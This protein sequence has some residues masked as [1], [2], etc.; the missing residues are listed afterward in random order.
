MRTILSLT[1]K[2]FRLFWKDKVAIALCFFVPMFLITV[3]GMIFTKGSGGPYGIRLLVVDEAQSDASAKLLQYLHDEDTF[4]VITDRQME[5]G[6]RVPIDRAYGQSLLEENAGSYRYLL[7]F[8]EDLLAEDFGLNLE[9][10]YNPQNGI[11]NGI[12]QG[13]LQKTLFSR[14]MPLLLESTQY[15]ITDDIR[16][17]F[18]TGMAGLIAEHFGGD[19]DQI[20]NEMRSNGFWGTGGGEEGDSDADADSDSDSDPDEDLFGGMF[21]FKKT[22][23]FG[24]GKNPASQSV[25]GWA[26]MFLLFSLSGAAS[27]LFEE[28]DKGLFLRLLSGPVSRTQILASKFLFCASLG[29]LQMLILLGFGQILYDIITDWRQVPP[30]LLVSVA[31]AGAATSFGMLLS[32]LVKTPAQAN[33]LATFLILSM[34]A[35][36]G[37]MF[38]LFMMPEFIRTWISPF[39]LVY[40]AMEGILAVLWRDAGILGVMPQVGVLAGITVVI[41]AIAVWRFRR[42][43]L[44]R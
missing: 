19:P 2:D 23:V 43:D 34:S 7:V 10:Y 31:A 5:D 4:H 16:E 13:I 11:E 17:S 25:G 37:A 39:M 18:D 35:F 20:L 33:G 21:N 12:V 1:A 22:Q 8:P 3:F 38:P 6:S 30:L 14:A 29:L 40:W 9:L 42:G 24:E 41:L 36:G 27:G 44:F 26:V 32:S 28:R 15:G